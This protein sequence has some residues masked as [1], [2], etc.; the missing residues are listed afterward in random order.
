VSSRTASRLDPLRVGALQ[1][2]R[3]RLGNLEGER[4]LPRVGPVLRHLHDQ[5]PL[6]GLLDR[7][8]DRAGGELRRRRRTGRRHDPQGGSGGVDERQ[9]RHLA[10]GL[11]LAAYQRLEPQHLAGLEPR[12]VEPAADADLGRHPEQ[13]A[14]RKLH[15]LLVLPLQADVEGLPAVCPHG[16]AAAGDGL[17]DTGGLN[18]LADRHLAGRLGGEACDHEQ[19]ENR[20]HG[21]PRRPAACWTGH[22]PTLGIMPDVF[23]GM[24]FFPAEPARPPS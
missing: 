18:L 15:A 24:R 1:S 14:V 10:V 4:H 17:D 9:R 20:P 23:D 12:N 21:G 3:R 16:Q 13:P 8:H 6:P 2:G 11:P 7:R 5:P 19:R 22:C